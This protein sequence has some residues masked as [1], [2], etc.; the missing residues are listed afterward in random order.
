M[1]KVIHEKLMLLALSTIYFIND[2]AHTSDLFDGR[3]ENNMWGIYSN[4]PGTIKW[5]QG[6]GVEDANCTDHNIRA[7]LQSEKT[8]VIIVKS[9][10][11][12]SI[13]GW[14]QSWFPWIFRK[15]IGYALPFHH[16]IYLARG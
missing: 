10:S 12:S 6:T 14:L 11:G 2:P 7:L 5:I 16:H 13:G 4:D 15:L 1:I 3:N 8:T 9:V